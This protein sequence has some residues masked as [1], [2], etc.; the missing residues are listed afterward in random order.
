MKILQCCV[1]DDE[2][3][4]A[5]LIKEYID[6]TPFLECEGVYGSAQ[7]A[8]KAVLSQEIDLIFLDIQMPQLNGLEFARIVPDRTKIVFT[9][10]YDRYAVEGFKVN[11]VDYLLKPVSYNEF[12]SAATKVM[13]QFE[14][15]EGSD[16]SDYIMVKSDYKLHQIPVKDIL[17]VE[18]VRDY[19]KIY[20]DS[21]APSILTLMSIKNLE[22]ALPK[23]SFM[24]VH[25]SYIVNMSKVR[26][27][28]RNRI[29]FGKT[30]IPISDTYKQEFS[31]YITRHSVPTAPER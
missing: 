11:A 27:I 28:E 18:G 3:L 9:T 5:G 29:V 4:A 2:P 6:R 31:D 21:E 8:I 24:R 19:V 16:T 1:I 30:L 25:R 14:A 20:L 12:L 7:E 10:A 23:S 17:Y 22:N 15:P 13:K 26:L